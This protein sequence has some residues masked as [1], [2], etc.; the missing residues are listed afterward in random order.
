MNL[1][2]LGIAFGV[3][4]GGLAGFLIGAYMVLRDHAD[5]IDDGQLLRS[6]LAD[7]A[8]SSRGGTP[9]VGDVRGEAHVTHL[10]VVHGG[11]A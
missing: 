9:L 3:C 11:V 5:L 1:M 2:L 6:L 4:A 7:A 8:T 10:R